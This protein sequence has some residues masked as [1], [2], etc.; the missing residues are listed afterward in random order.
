MTSQFS[1]LHA[2]SNGTS[3]QSVMY[4]VSKEDSVSSPRRSAFFNLE[5]HIYRCNFR[6]IF[7]YR[8]DE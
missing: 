3:V 4:V 5:C 6:E 7:I 2:V 1:I 8:F